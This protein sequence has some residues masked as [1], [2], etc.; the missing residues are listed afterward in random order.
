M[1]WLWLEH[2]K[3][4]GYGS[5][6][7]AKPVQTQQVLFESVQPSAIRPRAITGQEW[8]Q[9]LSLDSETL[10]AAWA[11]PR[12]LRERP[13]TQQYADAIRDIGLSPLE[14]SLLRFHAQAGHCS[15]GMAKLSEKAF[16]SFG[17]VSAAK[18][19]RDLGKCLC[20]ELVWEPDRFRNGYPNW[21][22]VIAECWSVPTG[23]T[24]WILI[25]TLRDVLGEIAPM[26]LVECL[27][28]HEEPRPFPS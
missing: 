25:G 14:S 21:T 13:T 11:R 2:L 12:P 1:W 20:E 6:F 15:I 9:H 4:G 3:A 23:Q 27:D 17:R 24:E 8:W 18:V 22:S 26:G 16:A 28:A 7:S 5:E 10:T 19:Y